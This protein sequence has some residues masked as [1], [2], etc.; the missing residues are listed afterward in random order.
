MVDETLKKRAEKLWQEVQIM[1]K[2]MAKLE[3]AR[4]KA[5]KEFI[6]FKRKVAE[7]KKAFP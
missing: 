3:K 2:E 7:F 6:L 1:S 5:K 4:K